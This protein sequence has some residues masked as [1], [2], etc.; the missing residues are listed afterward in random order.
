M[1]VLFG[2]YRPD[3]GE[4][5][6]RRRAGARST[7][8]GRR[9]RRRHR[10][11][12]PALHA[13][14]RCSPWPRTSCSASSPPRRLGRLDRGA[15]RRRVAELSERYGLA[16]D[17]DAIVEDLP[18]RRPAA[19]RDPQGALP[20]RPLPHPRRADRGAH[21]A[22]DRRADGDRPPAAPRAAGRSSSSATSCARCSRVADRITRPAP[23]A[24]SSGTHDPAETDEQALATMMVGRDVQLVVDKDA[25]RRPASAVLERQRPRR[26]RRP[27]PAAWSTA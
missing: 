20:R 22:G 14:A 13:G 16:V 15:A 8:A 10:H 17:P 25:G 11:G 9:H 6:A 12:A 1:N 19:G 4:I 3:E 26:R 5:L 7:V 24:R 27:R 21:A 23:A 18:G 2:L